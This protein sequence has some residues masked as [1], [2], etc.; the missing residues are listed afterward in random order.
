M[1]KSRRKFTRSEAPLAVKFRPT[2]GATDYFMGAVKNLSC[3][4]L[5]L[6][7]HD[8]RF[9][10]YEHLELIIDIRDNGGP[11]SLFGDIIWKKQNGK[12]C[13]AGIK[14][15]MKDKQLQEEAVR[16]IFS[17]SHIPSD[18]MYSNDADYHIHEEQDMQSMPPYK[19]GF[20]KLYNE[21]GATCRVTFR[22][23]RDMAKNADIVT[24]VGD[25]NDWDP[26][27]SSMTRLK[28]GD[29]VITID[30]NS[31]REY[32]FRYLIDGHRWENDRY[33]DKFVKN[34]FGAKDSIVIV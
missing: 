16:K 5:R 15:R 26:A 29:F 18:R 10:L 11:V 17:F 27:R 28:N 9:I 8:F 22:L 1:Q 4:G 3:E 20:I 24:I 31:R 13:L 21:N 12:R 19:L 2:Y 14:F 30:L 23:L 25:F 6:D 7:A 34:R 32:R 33:A